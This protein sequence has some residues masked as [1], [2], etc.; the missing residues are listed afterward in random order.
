VLIV[1]GQLVGLLV[2]GLLQPGLRRRLSQTLR[3]LVIPLACIS[4]AI[5]PALKILFEKI[6]GRGSVSLPGP[7]LTLGLVSNSLSALLGVESALLVAVSGLILLGAV[8]KL[9][10]DASIRRL[11]LA[12][13]LIFFAFV[14]V[15]LKLAHSFFHPRYLLPI[16]PLLALLVGSGIVRVAD[17]IRPPRLRALL[18]IA[19]TL[20]P[21][22]G[23]V[24]LLARYYGTDKRPWRSVVRHLEERVHRGDIILV[25]PGYLRYSL[26]YYL[27]VRDL[28]A[29]PTNTTIG[30]QAVSIGPAVMLTNVAEMSESRRLWYMVDRAG[31]VLNQRS[32]ELPSW[33]ARNHRLSGTFQ[34]SVGDLELYVNDESVANPGGGESAAIDPRGT[35]PTLHP[36]SGPPAAMPTFPGRRPR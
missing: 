4:I 23:N 1:A 17:V 14:M 31:L 13:T 5:L 15:T 35:A 3:S 24:A 22:V 29:S 7:E 16:L 30:D 36:T 9:P 27:G 21:I 34:G 19:V 2:V 10:G 6:S 26:L 20:L 28:Y 25:D 18:L 33:V 11:S 12:C 32:S 8:S